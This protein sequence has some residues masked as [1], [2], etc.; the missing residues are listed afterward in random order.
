MIL[1]NKKISIDESDVVTAVELEA[2]LRMA[3]NM[4]TL[5]ID[6]DNDIF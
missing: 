5:N 1:I 6:D 3:Y 4:Y 2:I